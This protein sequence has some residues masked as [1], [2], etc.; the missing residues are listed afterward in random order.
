MTTG[1]A[2]GFWR[3]RDR[4]KVASDFVGAQP[5]GDEVDDYRANVL[6]GKKVLEH[7]LNRRDRVTADDGVIEVD[8]GGK[9]HAFKGK[10][11]Q[12]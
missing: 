9:A 7:Q 2:N 12:G 3:S 10:P 4:D 5:A 1:F 6:F 8:E 11:I